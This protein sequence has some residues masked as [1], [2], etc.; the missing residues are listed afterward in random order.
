MADKKNLLLLFDRPREPVFMPKGKDNSVFDV[1]DVFLTN[2]YKNIGTEVQSRF[3]DDAGSKIPVQN[4]SQP[5]L[6][7][8]MQLGRQ[9]N[10]SLWIP[11]HRKIAGRLIDIFMGK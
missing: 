3:G 9:E 11:K 7:I 4:I 2:E 8:P 5:D 10:F 6:R 1:P